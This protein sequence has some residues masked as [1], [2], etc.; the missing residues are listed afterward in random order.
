MSRSHVPA[1][2][3]Q[4]IAAEARGRCGYCLT[5]EAITGAPLVLDHLIPEALGG[6]TEA[7]N[8][9]LACSQCN[10]HKGDRTTARDPLT[11]AWERL[12]D[13]RRQIWTEHFRWSESGAEI[14]GMTALDE[15]R[16]TRFN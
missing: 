8:L 16:Y 7:S 15:R 10:L 13:P 4:Q 5:P 1:R 11:E 3:R 6:L 12:F 14:I 9:W 2:L